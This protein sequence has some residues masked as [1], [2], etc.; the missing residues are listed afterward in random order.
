MLATGAE[1]IGRLDV[2]KTFISLGEG[3]VT[4]V[5]PATTLEIEVLVS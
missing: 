3:K 5:F 4:K 1:R 2:S